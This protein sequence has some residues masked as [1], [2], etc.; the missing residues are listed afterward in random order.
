MGGYRAARAPTRKGTRLPGGEVVVHQGD[1]ASVRRGDQPGDLFLFLWDI[2]MFFFLCMAYVMRDCR[3]FGRVR[4]GSLFFSAVEYG[5][6][7]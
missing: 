4:V 1:E 7:S 5:Q 3:G 2:R 6:R